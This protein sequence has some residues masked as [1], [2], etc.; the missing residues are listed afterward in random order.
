[1]PF[2]RVSHPSSM[3][4]SSKV[5]REFI[6]LKNAVLSSNLVQPREVN[7][8][9][10]NRMTRRNYGYSFIS[11]NSVLFR[12]VQPRSFTSIKWMT[13]LSW[14]VARSHQIWISIEPLLGKSG[15]IEQPIN[16]LT[17]ISF[18]PVSYRPVDPS[19]KTPKQNDIIISCGSS[20]WILHGIDS[21][22]V[23]Q[24]WC[25]SSCRIIPLSTPST[26]LVSIRMDV[27]HLAFHAGIRLHHSDDAVLLL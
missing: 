10:A 20:M 19:D 15:Q 7:I 6:S 5:S 9:L 18:S 3:T 12:F 4:S 11:P 25:W 23:P 26:P 27:M 1:M 16:Y 24:M 17:K 13:L 22:S 8:Q 21:T 14:C 2:F